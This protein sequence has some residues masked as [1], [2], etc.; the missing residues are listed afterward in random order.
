MNKEYT[1]KRCNNKFSEEV[2]EKFIKTTLKRCPF[3]DSP[4][5]V[6]VSLS[7]KKFANKTNK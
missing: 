1:C 6:L 4:N 3:C 7:K 5:V 2:T